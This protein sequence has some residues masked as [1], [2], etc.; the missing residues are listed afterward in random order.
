MRLAILDPKKAIW[1]GMAKKVTLPAADGEMCV[2]DFHQPF[3]VR[4]A[5]GKITFSGENLPARQPGIPIKDGIAFMR[6][7]SL[8]VFAQ[9]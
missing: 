6:S 9:T 3:V 4:L 1:Q 5:K 7:N 8:T 2:L